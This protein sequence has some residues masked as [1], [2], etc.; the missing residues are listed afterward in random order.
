[1]TPPLSHL[2][3]RRSLAQNA[4]VQNGLAFALPMLTGALP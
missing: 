1:M 3:R 2:F 4:Y